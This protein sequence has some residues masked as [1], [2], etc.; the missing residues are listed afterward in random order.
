[1]LRTAKVKIHGGD[2]DCSESVRMCYA[3]AGVLPWPYWDS[4]MWTG[5]EAEMLLS[6][7]F[8]KVPVGNAAQMRRG[9]VLLKTGHTEMYLGNGRQAGARGNEWG[10]ISGGEQGDQTG[11]ELSEGPYRGTA[12]WTTAFRYTGS[13]AVNG[14]P[15][16]EVAA[17]V[18][19]HLVM[20]DSAH[21]YDQPNRGGDGTV[22]EIT[23]QWEDGKP[24]EQEDEMNCIISVIG[25]N[26]LLWFDGHDINDLTHPAD[27]Q[28]LDKIYR[29]THDGKAMPRET[30]TGEELARLCQSIKGGYPKHLK[31]YVDK[32]PTRSPEA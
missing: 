28:V 17:Q 16:A 15:A 11:R 12:Q 9:D 4:Y 32:Y 29:A 31:K 27:V 23:V 19:E 3:A 7:G 6:H 18:M 20:H 25:E 2:Y 13:H 14:I 1:M 22:E 24:I 21:G 5:N 8:I 10:G 26:T 30:L